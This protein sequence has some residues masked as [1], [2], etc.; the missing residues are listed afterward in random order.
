GGDRRYC[1]NRDS[2]R[3][4]SRGLARGDRR[5]RSRAMIPHGVEI[6][7]GVEPIDLRWTFDR[8]SAIVTERIGRPTRRGTLFVFFRRRR[9]ALKVVCVD[10]TGLCLFYKRLDKGTFRLPEIEG[11]AQSVAI[12]ESMLDDLLDGIDV[13][14]KVVSRRTVRVH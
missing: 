7:V 3:I 11:D 6:F 13:E 9:E 10:G 2:R 5:A 8:F 14:T 12:E 4:R 1:A